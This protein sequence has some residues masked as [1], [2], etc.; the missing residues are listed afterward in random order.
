MA[1]TPIQTFG[2][3]I[4]FATTDIEQIQDIS[5][6]G[7]SAESLDI[8]NHDSPSAYREKIAVILDGGEVTFDMVWTSET[9]QDALRA[10]FAA[11][12][13]GAVVVTLPGGTTF[14]FQGFVS[15][16]NWNAPVAGILTASVT[17]TVAG[18]VT[19]TPA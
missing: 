9:G 11:R 18:V 8:T 13:T 2:T 19:V 12:T 15:G 1:T 6:P 16:W 14:G 4:S 3:A 7:E 17:M 5:G 10:A